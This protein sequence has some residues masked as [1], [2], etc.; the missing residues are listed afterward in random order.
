MDGFLEK[1]R[2]ILAADVPDADA[3]AETIAGIVYASATV[4]AQNMADE[5]ALALCRMGI[6]PNSLPPSR[7]AAFAARLQLE[8]LNTIGLLSRNTI[9]MP[10]SKKVRAA[11]KKGSHSKQDG[12]ELLDWAFFMDVCRFLEEHYSPAQSM[13]FRIGETGALG[14]DPEQEYLTLQPFS[15]AAKKAIDSIGCAKFANIRAR[16]VAAEPVSINDLLQE[17][18][19]TEPEA[20]RI[21]RCEPKTLADHRREGKIPEALYVQ[22]VENGT[23]HYVTKKLVTYAERNGHNKNPHLK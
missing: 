9:P 23:V 13:L 4:R 15:E 5:A 3:A 7:A 2:A 6:E 20:A 10:L 8:K 1:I 12:E 18:R 19:L 17:V 22:E 16:P 21:M 11:I 14:D